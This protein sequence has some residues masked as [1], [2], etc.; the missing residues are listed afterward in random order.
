MVVLAAF[1]ADVFP[2]V[3]V[4]NLS[5]TY[6]I[7]SQEIFQKIV[8]IIIVIFPVLDSDRFIRVCILI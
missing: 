5:A 3:Q 8:V 6:R 7:R 4:A 2:P 1:T